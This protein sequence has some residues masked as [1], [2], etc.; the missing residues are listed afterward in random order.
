VNNGKIY[1]PSGRCIGNFSGNQ[2][3][4]SMF[5]PGIFII[6]YTADGKH[7]TEKLLKTE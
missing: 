2:I 6:S 7:H 3:D 4:L 1:T 5:K